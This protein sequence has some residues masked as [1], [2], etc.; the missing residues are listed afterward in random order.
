MQR[1]RCEWMA[2][3]IRLLVQVSRLWTRRF[4]EWT[5][6]FLQTGA[7]VESARRSRNCIALAA[8]HALGIP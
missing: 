5:R 2:R 3:R 4:V 8:R 1:P 6:I 7:G